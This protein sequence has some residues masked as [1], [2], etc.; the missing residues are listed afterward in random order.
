MRVRRPLGATLPLDL[1]VRVGW[2]GVGSTHD[3]NGV[4]WSLRDVGV[5]TR[6]PPGSGRR[7]NWNAPKGRGTDPARLDEVRALLGNRPRRRDLLIEH[8]HL[9]Q[10]RHGALFP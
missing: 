6:I 4:G 1:G 8:F 5:S 2:N 10:D 7:T 3:G 9:L